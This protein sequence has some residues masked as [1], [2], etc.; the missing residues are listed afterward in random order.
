MIG[1]MKHKW[2]WLRGLLYGNW[3]ENIFEN[4]IDSIDEKILSNKPTNS[5]ELGNE[6]GYD[7]FAL[8]KR[9]YFDHVDWCDSTIR[10]FLKEDITKNWR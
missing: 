4:P 1:N 2:Q 7:V 5:T 10:P 9:S 3:S 6:L 8:S